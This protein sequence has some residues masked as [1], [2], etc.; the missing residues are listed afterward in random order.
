[1]KNP[2]VSVLV[3][4][5]NTA[6]FLPDCLQSIINQTY[7]NWELIIVDDGSTDSSFSIVKQF[8]DNDSKI[9]GLVL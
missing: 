9:M 3:P 5:K 6:L 1:M 8:A 7:T 2:L 4:F